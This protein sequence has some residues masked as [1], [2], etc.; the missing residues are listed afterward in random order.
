M[1]RHY[2][3]HSRFTNQILQLILYL[4]LLL[5]QILALKQVMTLFWCN[6]LVFMIDVLGCV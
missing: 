5:F 4:W 2:R 3:L 6:T 1:H